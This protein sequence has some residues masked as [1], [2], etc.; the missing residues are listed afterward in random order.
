MALGNA[1]HSVDLKDRLSHSKK[2]VVLLDASVA[3]SIR[4]AHNPGCDSGGWLI[5]YHMTA[6]DTTTA[7]TSV[8]GGPAYCCDYSQHNSATETLLSA[9]LILSHQNIP[10]HVLIDTGCV[11][12]NIVSEPVANLIR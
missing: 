7:V 12:T 3:E 11:Q 1:G 5:I 6:P 2:R 9:F 8:E 4:K 10:F